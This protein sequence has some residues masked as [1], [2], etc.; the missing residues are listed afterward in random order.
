ML[1]NLELLLRLFSCT[2]LPGRE[3]GILVATTS[4]ADGESGFL[5]FLLRVTWLAFGGFWLSS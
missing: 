3:F 2:G 4:D 5:V 1:A